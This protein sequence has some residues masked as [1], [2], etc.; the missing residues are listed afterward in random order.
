MSVI[1]AAIQTEGDFSPPAKYFSTTNNTPAPIT[2]TVSGY[3][4]YTPLFS[5]RA[6]K[7]FKGKNNRVLSL[8]YEL[9][10]YSSTAPIEILVFKNCTLSGSLWLYDPGIESALEGDVHATEV[11]GVGLAQRTL[12]SQL[13]TPGQANKV[14]L[15]SVFTFDGE[16]IHRK[17][18][19]DDD[20]DIYTVAAITMQSDHVTYVNT[21]VSWKQIE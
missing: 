2:T 6:K 11:V 18:D 19:I 15:S 17:S 21:S 12:F 16:Q 9:S 14:D 10:V 7:I 4:T 5:G 20:P 1:C 8:P 3:S 13:I